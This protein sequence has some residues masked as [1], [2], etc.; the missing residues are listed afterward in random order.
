MERLHREYL[1]C[2]LVAALGQVR[3]K[4]GEGGRVRRLESME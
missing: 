3:R 4:G 1:R 2:L